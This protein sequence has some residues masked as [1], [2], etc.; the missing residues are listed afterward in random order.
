M[1]TNQT[2]IDVGFSEE[3][4]PAGTHMCLIYSDEKERRRIVSK[5]L[6]GGFSTV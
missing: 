6:N 1:C 2:M 5:F 4:F 3:R